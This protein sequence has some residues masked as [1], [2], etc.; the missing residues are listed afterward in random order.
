VGTLSTLVAVNLAVRFKAGLARGEF[1][2]NEIILPR[3]RSV[4][5]IFYLR[6]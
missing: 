6:G 4:S 1:C 5:W 2:S 3:K